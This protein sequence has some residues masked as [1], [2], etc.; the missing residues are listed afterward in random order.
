MTVQ[1]GS[2]SVDAAARTVDVV[3]VGAGFAGLYLLHRLRGLGFS[4]VVLESA[5]DVGGTWYWNRYPG[6]RCDIESIDY[7]YSF[8]PELDS[9]WQWSEKYATQPEILRYLQHVADKH[10]LRRD[11]DVRHAGR[12]GGLGRGGVTLARA[13]RARRRTSPAA[14]R[15]GHRLPVAAEGARHRG[16]RPLP[17][18]RLLHQP[19]A[20]RGRRL[21]RQAGGG[22]RHGL[23]GRP[24]DPDHR[25]A[26]RRAHRLPAHA[27][28]SRCR[29]TTARCRRRSW[30]PTPSDRDAYR[31]AARWSHGRRAAADPPSEGAFE[32]SE[33]ERLARYEDDVGVR[34][35]ARSGRS[36]DLHRQRGGQRDRLRVPPR[37]D[38]LDRARPRDGRGALP[39]GPLLS[40]PSA[41]ASTPTTTRR[42]TCPT[43]AWSTCASTP[44]TTITE[45]GIDHVGRVVRVRRH[46]VRHRLRRHDR[47]DR[48]PSTSPGRDGRLA[49]RQVGGRA[50]RPTSG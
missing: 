43:S 13:H 23:V 42:S 48:R 5:D 29:P 41:R 2:G 21:H 8:D 38:P 12:P 15:D 25:R 27:R 14:L 16:R 18:R 46:R 31:E 20:A 11:I 32:V 33:E 50:R 30:T 24:V 28:T 45:T 22:D 39:E 10:D 7:S 9:E 37:Q 40:A 49:G 3:V 4:A 6:A 26:G 35:P 36:A 44:I 34:R 19:L 17:G 1:N 47:R